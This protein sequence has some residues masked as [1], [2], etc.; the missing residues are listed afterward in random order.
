MVNNDLEMK[1]STEAFIHEILGAALQAIADK[2]GIIINQLDAE[3]FDVSDLNEPS[4]KLNR[5]QLV[6]TSHYENSE[7]E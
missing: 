4:A 1:V 2:H 7:Q 5:I 3:W 6:T